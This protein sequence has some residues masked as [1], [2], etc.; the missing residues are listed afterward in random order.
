MTLLLMLIQCLVLFLLILVILPKEYHIV[1]SI[2]VEKPRETVFNF[3]RFFKQHH[4]WSPCATHDPSLIETFYGQ[5]GE[6]G[7]VRQWKGNRKYGEG[8]MEFTKV[9]EGERIEGVIHFKRPFRAIADFRFNF[10]DTDKN[11]TKIEWEMSGIKPIPMLL[12][13]LFLS[14]DRIVGKDFEE[15]LTRIK[16]VMETGEYDLT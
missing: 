14:M 1:R 2:N 8:E 15:G 16:E 6:V 7:I 10:Q 3:L 9:V 11:E 13:S 12:G 4:I 5:D